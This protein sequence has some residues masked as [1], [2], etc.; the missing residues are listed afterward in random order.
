MMLPV[1]FAL[2]PPPGG[3]LVLESNAIFAKDIAAVLPEFARVP[4]DLRLGYAFS[5]GAPAMFRGAELQGLARNQGV[6]LKS[7]LPDVCFVRRTFVPQPDQIRDAMR[8]ALSD[9]PGI[10]NAKIEI[11]AQSQH[12]APSGEIVFPGTGLPASP[13]T[14]L[15]VLWR[16]YVHYDSGE[17]PIWARARI[18]TNTTRVVAVAN[19]PSGK[20]IQKSQVRLESCEDSL[21][22]QTTARNLDEV[23]GY[24]PKNPLRINFPISKTQLASPSDVARGD[25]VTVQVTE[26]AARLVLEAQAQSAGVKGSTIV[27]RNLSSGKEFRARVVGKNRVAIGP[28]TTPE[29]TI[30]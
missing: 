20:P 7:A 10:E 17:F 5:S 13:G 27:V 29:G 21:L 8:A 2:A 19:L 11:S 28:V 14:G 23:I 24:L 15:E 3:C 4:G 6:E 25:L 18:T 16:G 1:L 9:V 26:G 12:P 22:D 30:Q